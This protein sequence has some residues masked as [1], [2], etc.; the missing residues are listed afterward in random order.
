A[1]ETRVPLVGLSDHFVSEAVYLSDPDGHGIEIYWDRPRELGAGRV[2]ERVT[3]LPLDVS[4]LLDARDV[5]RPFETLPNGTTVGHVH[6][7]VSE[8]PPTVSF[9]RDV[10]GFE[11][12]AGLGSTAA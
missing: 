11:L 6:L 9:Y 1:A 4:D 3:T 5:E 2:A 10:L 7:R 12:T 8:I